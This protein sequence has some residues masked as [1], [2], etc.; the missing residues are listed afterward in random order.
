MSGKPV[1]E[2]VRLIAVHNAGKE[3]KTVRVV[4]DLPMA[5]GWE[6]EVEAT[7]GGVWDAAAG[8]VPWL[9]AEVPADGVWEAKVSIRIVVP[10]RG[11]HVVGL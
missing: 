7:G 6:M 2:Q 11:G 10:K 3:N 4:E 1:I 8:E 9:E 5:P